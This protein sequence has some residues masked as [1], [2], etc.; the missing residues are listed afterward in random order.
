LSS[1]ELMKKKTILHIL[2]IFAVSAG[3][4]FITQSWFMS[5]GIMMIILLIDAYLKQY[6]NKRR[7]EWLRKHRKEMEEAQQE[8]EEKD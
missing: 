4:L 2:L 6:D 1:I 7:Q 8:E 5:L 3:L